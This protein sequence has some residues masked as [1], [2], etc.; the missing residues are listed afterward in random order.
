MLIDLRGRA[1][2]AAVQLIK[3]WLYATR[4]GCMRPHLV[5]LA[6]QRHTVTQLI[7]N[8][9][10]QP[11]CNTANTQCV[12]YTHV[13]L[14]DNRTNESTRKGGESTRKCA[15]TNSNCRWAGR[16]RSERRGRRQRRRRRMRRRGERGGGGASGS[17]AGC[18]FQPPRTPASP[19]RVLWH[20]G[21]A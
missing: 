13:I 5:V 20:S 8:H 4:F 2:D 11:H 15:E 9:C 18:L 7:H 1:C 16:L 19:S 17:I 6:A 21:Q 14:Q 3:I 12:T 10:M